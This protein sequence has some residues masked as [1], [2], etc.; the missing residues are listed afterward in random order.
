M[1]FRRSRCKSCGAAIVWAESK[2]GRKWPFDYEPDDR[3]TFILFVELGATE[4]VALA[5]RDM[6][7]AL[8]PLYRERY[9]PHWVSCP[10]ADAHRRAR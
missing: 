6:E 7:R 10:N 4:P 9:L 1:N 2:N 5:P 3:G 8:L